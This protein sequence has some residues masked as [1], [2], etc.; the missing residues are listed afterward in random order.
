MFYLCTNLG[1]MKRL[2]TL[3]C[4]CLIALGANCAKLEEDDI[5]SVAEKSEEQTDSFRLIDHYLLTIESLAWKRDSLN[6]VG[7]ASKPNAY[8]FELLTHPT[9]YNSPLHQM[10]SRADSTVNDPQLQRL[11][12]IRKMLSSLYTHAPQLVTQTEL[13]LKGQAAIRSDVNDKLKNS[14]D[15]LAEKVI[16]ATL[17]PTLDQPVEV[18]TRRPNFWKFSGNAALQF[19][20]NHF[21]ENWYK[22]GESN[23]AGLATLQ[24]RGNYDD[25]R[26]IKWEN[27]LDAQLGFQTTESDKVHSIRP[28]TNLLRYTT[29]AGYK[30]WKN[31]FYSLQVILQTQIVP[32]YQKN[33][34]VIISKIF[35]PLEV[36]VAPGMKY[37]IAW[38]KKKQFTG[39]L[40]VAPLA[41]KILYVGSDTLVTNFG[42]EKGEHSKT[43]FG[44]N[45]TLNTKWQICK[46]IA[47]TSRVY[48]MTN[49]DYNIWEWENTI[50]F[51]IT[52]LITARMSLYPRYDD[53]NE[54]YRS[55]E[56]HD[57]TYMMFKEW[58]SLG[59]SYSF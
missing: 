32:N 30:A 12:S 47:W 48:W 49:F 41:M 54:K 36:T 53:S 59:L 3:F 18:I 23:F 43:T 8:F 25:Q 21:S 58:F 22:G 39:T 31:L 5:P 17:A 2:T 52:K 50:D 11:Y 29:N 16:A 19:S 51:S 57:G 42:L 24:L 9:L 7:T 40:N 28:T 15:K 26:K 55:G 33:N 6:A 1:Q 13:D 45:I 20:Q 44:P 46:Q 38:G 4:I 56:N 27:T 37:E 14:D 34:D 35:S 10:M